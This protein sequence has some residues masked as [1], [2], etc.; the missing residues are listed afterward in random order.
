VP[1]LHLSLLGSLD[2]CYE[3]QPL[4]KPPTLKS[5]SLLAYLAIHRQRPQTRER[6]AG[7]FWGERPE[8]RARRSLTTAMWHIR[9]CL[10]DESLLLSDAQSVQF[11]PQADLWVD[12]D[13]FERLLSSPDSS[14]LRSAVELYRGDFM[15]GYYDDWVLDERYRLE[16]LYTDALARLM[17][18]LEAEADHGSA[19]NIAQRLLDLDPLR[20]DAHRLIMRACC[21]LGRRNAAF[22]GYRR[23]QEIVAREL[24][25]EPMAETTALY[26]A[27]LNGEYPV[28]PPVV[29]QPIV[30]VGVKPP[31]PAGQNPLEPFEH[32]PLVGRETEMAYLQARFQEARASRG[33]FTLVQ[34]EAGVG[35]T[36]LLEEFADYLGWQGARVLWGRCYEFERL[37]P[38]Q[39]LA[40]ALQAPLAILSPVD[41]EEFPPWV[42]GELT[43]LI[44]ELSETLAHI[45]TPSRLEVEQD[46]A[47]LFEAVA[48]VLSHLS[49][50]S[51]LALILDD[52]HWAAESTLQML[53]YLI[54]HLWERP[55]LIIAALRP[56]AVEPGHEL[57]RFQQQLS[58]E[59]KAWS[60]HLG[61]LSLQTV[62]SLLFEMS[63]GCRDV[64]PLVR[65]LY[66][67]TEGNPFFL[68]E[69]V[70]ALFESGLVELQEGTWI[71]DFARI[72]QA[73]LPL[74][75]GLSA[76]IQSRVRRL[77]R[78]VQ[79]AL[80][81]AAILGREF[82]FDLLA[83][84][85]GKDEEAVME[86]LDALLR[87]RFIREGSGLA[88][89]DYAFQHHKIQ[90]VVYA[91]IPL[92][93]RNRL[94][95]QAGTTFELLGAS[96]LHPIASELAFHFNLGRRADKN[97]T[98]KAI[99]YLLMSGDQARQ[100]YAHPEAI[101]YY[102]Q[103]L[104][105]LKAGGE[106]EEAGRTLMKLGLVYHTDFDYEKARRAFEE[107][108]A[109]LQQAGRHT[110]SLSLSPAPH[111]LRIRWRSPY[112][113]DPALCEEYVSSLVI[114]QM[115][116]GLLTTGPELEI[117]PEVAERWE[118]LDSGR[119]YR[120][121][122]RPDVSWSDGVPLTAHDFEFAW[123][124]A[125]E[126]ATGVDAVMFYVIQGAR[127]FQEGRS[128]D[129]DQVAIRALDD[130]TLEVKLEEPA[131]HFL[132]MLTDVSLSP[133]P[134]HILAAH[135]D[136][137][138]EPDK[139][140]SNGPFMLD[141]W[142]PG[143]SMRLMRN[144]YYTGK[145]TGNVEA[146]V[147][148][149]PRD[150][151]T[152]DLTLPLDQYA[153]GELDVLTLTDASVHE[154]DRIRRQ[155]ASEYVSAPWLFTIYLGCIVSRPPFDDPRMRQALALA[156]DR[157]ELANVVLRG[158]YTPGVG[159][160]IP[161]F[162]PGHSPHIGLPYDPERGRRL[163]A[164]AGYPSGAGL[165]VL[166]ALSV[167]PIDPLV[168]QFLQRQW[169]ENLGIQVRWEVL[170]W[171]PFSRRLLEAP[172]HLFNLARFASWPDPSR[173]LA[174]DN[175]IQQYTRWENQAYD[176]LVR[177]SEKAL[178]QETRFGF[179]QKADQLLIEE[180]AII[181]LFYGRQ[182]VLVKPWVRSFPISALNRWFW[183]DAVIEP[184]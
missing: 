86:A 76:A 64:A 7:L 179:L 118:V 53:H 153:Q 94:H 88:G 138:T 18:C 103:A 129:P 109:H 24:N 155:Y 39:P 99:H 95:A 10:P 149:F 180:A 174:S 74:P 143:E 4:T 161:P 31:H 17:T 146:V 132:Y 122:L 16:T 107:G 102:A 37:L 70:K 157:Q 93:H 56:E 15:D 111:S 23:C 87:R 113:L 5:Q 58:R 66:Q 67:E 32:Y 110:S 184:H 168:T 124:R 160:F 170:D 52:L 79:R 104:E 46:Q 97:L 178:D 80:Q 34:G 137:W 85:W 105:L 96:D 12:V 147:L 69:M 36:R 40:E 136:A 43:R 151:A 163:L 116:R 89:R 173:I 176:S 55:I 14:S 108:F 6:L 134:Q 165:P 158:M 63:G 120:F 84:V 183:Q 106:H 22:E 112:T 60:L 29:V 130:H 135:G 133:V 27:I 141:S 21:R 164:K 171:P 26:Q 1:A 145:R 42:L 9:R 2:I 148:Q 25:A 156:I 75:A 57:E 11:D 71:G 91:S 51:A 162:M 50:G 159:G 126:L 68:T 59:G 117:V 90:E 172:P 142:Q 35:K 166:E 119:R 154:G 62:E 72:S 152:Q 78:D 38:Y 128:R 181:P 77:D 81:V 82:D 167:P 8:R 140:V 123:K 169:W 28:G 44:P 177:Q 54:R 182:H 33:G 13:E 30:E 65:R 41:L 114:S 100:A 49:A 121:H 83:E 61:G 144:P 101:R 92:Q 19:L 48:R 3:G 115:F 131:N 98:P 175:S 125:F 45:H 20:E 139:I 127:D 73:E 47:H 150:Q